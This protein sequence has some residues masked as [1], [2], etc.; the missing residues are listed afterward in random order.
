MQHGSSGF[1]VW[2]EIRHPS[3]KT[4]VGNVVKAEDDKK[5]AIL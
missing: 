3:V 1:V 4:L 2:A 5:N